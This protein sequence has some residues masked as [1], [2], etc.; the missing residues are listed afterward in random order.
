MCQFKRMVTQNIWKCVNDAKE[1]FKAGQEAAVVN[2]DPP[3]EGDRSSDSSIYATK[4]AKAGIR[5]E[6]ADRG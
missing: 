6:P 2:K 3:L 1:D 4:E 5:R